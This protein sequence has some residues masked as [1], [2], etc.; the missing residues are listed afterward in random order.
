MTPLKNTNRIQLALIQTGGTACFIFNVHLLN[1]KN[2]L[3]TITA[4]DIQKIQTVYPST[5]IICIGDFYIESPTI[6]GLK[7][8]SP[9]TYTFF[10][11]TSTKSK[12]DHIF[13]SIHIA[14]QEFTAEFINSDHKAIHACLTSLKP[15]IRNQFT[16]FNTIKSK[17]L[18][19]SLNLVK[20]DRINLWGTLTTQQFRKWL[21]WENYINM[22]NDELKELR[23][24]NWIEKMN[25]LDRATGH[26][27]FKQVKLIF[28]PKDTKSIINTVD[29]EGVVTTNL[30]SQ[31]QAEKRLIEKN[32][33]LELYHH[34]PHLHLTPLLS[35]LKEA[36][37]LAI[38]SHLLNMNKT[39]GPDGI[40]PTI[41]QKIAEL[42]DISL[43]DKIMDKQLSRPGI[44]DTRPVLIQ[45]NV[46]DDQQQIKV[47]PIQ[48]RN[49]F[50]RLVEK[51]IKDR[52]ELQIRLSLP[53]M[54][55]GFSHGKDTQSAWNTLNNSFGH[56][57]TR[58]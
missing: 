52:V 48:V 40:H 30:N 33:S 5:N 9:L 29:E 28:K 58:K 25:Q 26:D 41:I 15:L 57:P 19:K 51:G 46:S 35:T 44:F 20:E 23:K 22:S 42:T 14:M 43:T 17:K 54:Q 38:N 27:I 16:V 53:H 1:A 24:A 7:R 39:Y 36:V 49:V 12:L 2:K 34:N 55:H 31:I 21:G 56:Y 3:L 37:K 11:G 47:R 13:T 10:R 4:K 6:T 8:K 32:S 50:W 45:K 18:T